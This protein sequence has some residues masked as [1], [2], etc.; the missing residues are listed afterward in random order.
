[1]RRDFFKKIFPQISFKK[2]SKIWFDF[3]VAFYS[4]FVS[5]NFEILNKNLTYYFIDPNGVSSNFNYLT[6]NW[7][8]RR[9]EAHNFYKYTFEKFSLKFT[10]TFD[11]ILTKIISVIISFFK[12]L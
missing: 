2:F 9:L 10:I 7:W 4:Y 6:F 12:K 1:M 11:Y 3:R 5:K 8:I